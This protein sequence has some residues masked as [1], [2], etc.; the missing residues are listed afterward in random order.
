MAEIPVGEQW[1]W[2]GAGREKRSGVWEERGSIEGGGERRSGMRKRGGRED[3]EE[4]KEERKEEERKEERYEKGEGKGEGEGE[5]GGEGE[6][7]GEGEG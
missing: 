5:G 7:E 6:G 3:E 2:P 1:R 4:R